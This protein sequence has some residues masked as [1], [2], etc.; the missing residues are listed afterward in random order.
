VAEQHYNVFKVNKRL[1]E[2][3]AEKCMET[4]TSIVNYIKIKLR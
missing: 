4:F 3:M 1:A 2:K